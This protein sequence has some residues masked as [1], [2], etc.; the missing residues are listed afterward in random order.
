MYV[1]SIFWSRASQV[2]KPFLSYSGMKMG[3]KMPYDFEAPPKSYFSINFGIGLSMPRGVT[4]SCSV[5][6]RTNMVLQQYSVGK[7]K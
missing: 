1:Y 3:L 2:G 5:L 4:C 7:E 6:S